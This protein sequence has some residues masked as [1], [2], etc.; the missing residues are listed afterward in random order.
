MR[1]N[2][3]KVQSTLKHAAKELLS[4]CNKGKTNRVLLPKSL[5]LSDVIHA[6]HTDGVLACTFD[7]PNVVD[8]TEEFGLKF[9]L[10]NDKYIVF[11]AEGS[12]EK[13]VSTGTAYNDSMNSFKL[14]YWL[15]WQ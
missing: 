12:F 14:L 3:H 11:L 2:K 5:G 13:Q 15:F 6:S 4:R 10:I 7:R 1:K 8:L 9:D